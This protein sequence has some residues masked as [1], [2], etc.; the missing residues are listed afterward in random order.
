[1]PV[2]P[3][4]RQPWPACAVAGVLGRGFPLENAAA[5]IC[6]EAGG[7]VRTN[8]LHAINN[9][10]SRRLKDV[11][12][13]LPLIRGA[14]LAIDT[15]LVSPL[16]RNGTARPRCATESGAALERARTRKERRAS[17]TTIPRTPPLALRNAL[18]RPLLMTSKASGG[19]SPLARM[20]ANWENKLR[21]SSDYS[22]AN[23]C[24]FVLPE[25]PG[26]A[27]GRAFLMF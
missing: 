4:P 15:T 11:V 18:I 2:R 19:M 22:T 23:K 20:P 8:V 26:A 3:S 1:M 17:P 7:G 24:S 13:G 9:L 5:R 27:P 14:Q 21:S 6:R 25:G 16:S 12:D 10:D